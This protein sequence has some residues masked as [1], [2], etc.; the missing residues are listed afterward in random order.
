MGLPLVPIFFRALINIR[1]TPVSNIN[2]GNNISSSKCRVCMPLAAYCLLVCIVFTEE[3]AGRERENSTVG[4]L[5]GK[6][7]PYNV[8]TRRFPYTRPRMLLITLGVR[9]SG[10]TWL[11]R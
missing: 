1:K 11:A 8:Y 7:P 4:D 6:T 9:A 10:R 2:S 5:N 3:G